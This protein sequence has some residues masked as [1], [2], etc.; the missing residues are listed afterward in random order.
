MIL[1]LHGASTAPHR[2]NE[3]CETTIEEVNKQE[4]K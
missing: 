2:Q 3:I 4:S 1:C